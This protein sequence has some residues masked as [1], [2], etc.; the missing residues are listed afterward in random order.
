MIDAYAAGL[1]DG[2]GCIY[3]TRASR[4]RAYAP[5]VDVG[6]TVKANDLLA[7]LQ[8][9]YGG[10]VHLMRSRSDRWEEAR[11]WSV[12]GS[13][14]LAFLERVLPYLRLKVEQAR[15]AIRVEEI[16]REAARPSGRAS[17]SDEMVARAERLRLRIRELNRKGP[18]A[19]TSAEGAFALLVAGTWRTPQLDLF[20]DLGSP[21]FSGTWPRSGSMRS[22]TA[23]E[24]PTS[25][26]P[27]S[28]SGSSSWPTP[29]VSAQ[30][31]S[32]KALTQQHFSG[33]ALEQAVELSAGIVPREVSSI[34][35]LSPGAQA[36]WPTPKASNGDKAGRP[37]ENNWGDL[38]AAALT[39]PTPTAKGNDNRAGASVKSSDGL[40]TAVRWA[41]P[42]S[43]DGDG[44]GSAKGNRGARRNLVDQVPS[45]LNPAWVE[46]L[47]GYPDGW[48]WLP[49]AGRPRPARRPRGSRPAPS[50][51]APSPTGAP[52]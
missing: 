13:E 1:I 27:T 34:D 46:A 4:G 44:R 42:K 30:R 35:E 19:T 25:V 33:V 37:R 18:T 45:A 20:S 11:C 24:R 14:A 9:S 16:R 31:N 6:M 47:M 50:E 3:I 17:W 12:W 40:G 7:S 26:R 48:T 21:T 8:A 41:T 10:T 38:Q 51:A 23:S 29:K 2:E 49:T 36:L 22:G 28:G 15:L 32:R 39:W 52:G 5:R 43:S